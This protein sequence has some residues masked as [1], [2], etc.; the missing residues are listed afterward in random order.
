MAGDG[1]TRRVRLQSFS[2]MLRQEISWF[3]KEKNATGILVSRL[4]DDARN[5]QG[6]RSEIEVYIIYKGL[7]LR[8]DTI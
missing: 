7:D 2:A 1:L 8:K 3:D 4:T 6:V 5:V